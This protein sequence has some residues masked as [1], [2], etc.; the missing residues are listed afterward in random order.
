MS[1]A[2]KLKTAFLSALIAV[3]GLTLTSS[4]IRTYDDFSGQNL[5]ANRH[6]VEYTA[7]NVLSAAFNS[8]SRESSD[9]VD[10]S[11]KLPY[12]VKDAPPTN[13]SEW[14]AVKTGNVVHAMGDETRS[15]LMQFMPGI[16]VSLAGLPGDVVGS[17]AGSAA[18][19]LNPPAEKAPAPQTTT[20]QAKPQAQAFK[21]GS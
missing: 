20:A 21:R 7:G 15:S 18:Y 4:A 12:E 14:A 11:S 19:G 17:L 9:W 8:S 16:V 6:A 1:A 2:K 13:P 3:N 5:P 10:Y